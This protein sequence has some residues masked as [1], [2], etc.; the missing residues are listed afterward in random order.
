[1]TLHEFKVSLDQAR[2]P[3]LLNPLLQ[4]L[5]HEAKGDWSTAHQLAQD[6]HTLEGSW[7][8]G[9]LH[10]REGDRSNAA[11]RNHHANHSLATATL[12]KEWE[13][14]AIYLLT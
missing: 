7:V 1:M 13:E 3:E 10:L 11:Y 2:P 4:A 6:V 14:L 5:W 9:Y 12:E 8:H